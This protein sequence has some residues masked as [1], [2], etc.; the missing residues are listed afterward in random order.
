MAAPYETLRKY[1]GLSWFVYPNLL[2]DWKL[3]TLQHFLQK[4]ISSALGSLELRVASDGE[5]ET[6][7]NNN[8]GTRTN[9]PAD[10][11]FNNVEVG[12]E[13]LLYLPG[14]GAISG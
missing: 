14:F 7:V 4:S 8:Y 13:S 9:G 10:N 1:G 6:P 12:R 11:N 5:A 2:H 3:D